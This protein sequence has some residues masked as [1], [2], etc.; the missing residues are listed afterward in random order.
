MGE[1]I[2]KKSDGS[3][4][5]SV[6]R[7]DETG[8]EIVYFYFDNPKS[9]AEY[10]TKR[11]GDAPPVPYYDYDRYIGEYYQYTTLTA[12]E[13]VILRK[14]HSDS[15]PAVVT[16]EAKEEFD[17]IVGVVIT[18]Q[19]RKIKTMKDITMYC[20]SSKLSFKRGEYINVTEDSVAIIQQNP[21]P[22]GTSRETYRL[23][24]S[25]AGTWRVEHE[26]LLGWLRRTAS[27]PLTDAGGEETAPQ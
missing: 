11:L 26:R 17:E 14:D 3:N 10:Q 5:L 1:K 13:K 16:I 4:S 7:K 21:G 23:L 18:K 19:P 25:E 9:C 20:G 12:N 2:T 24:Y 27:V 22:F 15:S 8:K 6:K